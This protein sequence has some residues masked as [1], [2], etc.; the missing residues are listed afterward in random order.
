MEINRSTNLQ[1]RKSI[2]ITVF[3]NSPRKKVQDII[4]KASMR[5]I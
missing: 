1:S 2:P 5:G 4:E 3:L